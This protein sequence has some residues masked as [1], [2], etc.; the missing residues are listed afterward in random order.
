MVESAAL[1]E[2]RMAHKAEYKVI[3]QNNHAHLSM[4]LN[5]LGLEGWKPILMTT[6]HAANAAGVGNVIVT[7][8]LEHTVGA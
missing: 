2:R 5:K 6:V 3:Q 4:E 8:I 7:V 1:E